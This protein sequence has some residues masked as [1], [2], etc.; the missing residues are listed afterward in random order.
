MNGIKLKIHSQIPIILAI[1]AMLIL[2]SSCESAY[3]PPKPQL[4]IE[5]YITQDD[6]P[7]ICLTR[8]ISPEL[9]GVDVSDFIVKWGKVTLSDGDTTVILTGGPDKSFFPPYTYTTYEMKGRTGVKYTLT[10]EYEDDMVT[11]VTMIPEPAKIDSL[12]CLSVGSGKYDL[13]LYLTSSYK[14]EYFTIRTHIK[15]GRGALPSFMGTYETEG[16]GEEIVC[17][18]KRPNVDTDTCKYQSTFD[19]GEELMVTLCN[20]DHD[21]FIFWREYD[22]AVAFGGSQFLSPSRQLQGNVK[23]GLGYFLG[24]GSD[25]RY[26]KIGE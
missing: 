16:K 17:A 25:T 26:I 14:K 9:P 24:Y 8:T 20:I 18:V 11:A 21:A 2:M 22:N 3:E 4:C 19:K 15:G 5:G 7:V 12:K 1:V 13:N 10:A 23:G 6:Y